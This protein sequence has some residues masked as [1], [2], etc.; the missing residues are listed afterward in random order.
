MA[1]AFDLENIESSPQPD[2]LMT[3]LIHAVRVILSQ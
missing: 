2:I 1:V 3:E